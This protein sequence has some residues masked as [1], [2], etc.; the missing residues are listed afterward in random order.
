M[1]SEI[2]TNNCLDPK[3]LSSP[4]SMELLA[5][6]VMSVPCGHLVE[7]DE[8]AQLTV[9]KI[10]N[11]LC[12]RAHVN[13]WIPCPHT[14]KK[15]LQAEMQKAHQQKLISDDDIKSIP[16]ESDL[17][18]VDKL[19]REIFLNQAFF[20]P[21]MVAPC[22]CVTEKDA[23]VKEIFEESGQCPCCQKAATTLIDYPPVFK[24]LLQL[25]FNRMLA[26]KQISYDELSFDHHHF[27]MIVGAR[28]F[29]TPAGERFIEVL[30]NSQRHLN[31]KAIAILASTREGRD[32]LRKNLKIE[33][34]QFFFKNALISAE[35]LQIDVDG[36]NI[37]AWLSIPT[38]VEIIEEE[39]EKT[40]AL[41][42]AEFTKAF[43]LKEQ[44][45]QSAIL[46]EEQ[47]AF[48]QLLLSARKQG[49]FRN[50]VTAEYARESCNAVDEILQQVVYGQRAVVRATL[51]NLKNTNPALLK[52]VLTSVSTK[53][54]TDY[55][56]K[57]IEN[58]TLLQAAAAANDFT[59]HPELANNPAHQ[60]MCDIIQSYFDPTDRTEQA[61]VA[62]QY[63]YFLKRSLQQYIEE[64]QKEITRLTA[65]KAAGKT[66]DEKCIKDAT[67]RL[68][69]YKA[70][71]DTGYTRRIFDIHKQAQEE[72]TF[73][74]SKIIAAITRAGNAPDQ[75]RA[76]LKKVGASFSEADDATRAKPDDQLTL[77]ESLNRFREQF[78]RYALNKIAVNPYDLIKA[79]QTYDDQFN[80]WA[81]WGQRF[82]FA[83]QIIGFVQRYL[84]AADACVFA[85][86]LYD[87]VDNKCV[88]P[89]HFTFENDRSYHFYPNLR[90]CVGLGFDYLAGWGAGPVC[91]GA[92]RGAGWWLVLASLQNLCRAKTADFQNLCSSALC[93]VA[94][95]N[96]IVAV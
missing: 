93:A 63:K 68:T 70:A 30:E 14:F 55:S 28:K 44:E 69:R 26:Q 24:E 34:G 2:T 56:G 50:T 64:Q 15:I 7:A 31:G 85:R 60:G 9:R 52:K 29:N 11:C 4:I 87:T 22:G 47:Q 27:S 36:K 72:N 95:P 33:S 18:N 8:A 35:S 21:M 42:Q 1:R 10:E 19:A 82:L 76:A 53:P 58:L 23:A 12:C 75:V 25:R 16:F 88:V 54:I 51:E 66:V 83:R 61:E 77:T 91:F 20:E 43:Y 37:L 13:E 78:E 84:S 40:A 41:M 65:L 80:N 92:S 62:E 67:T 90:L 45:K 79:F 96:T 17:E 6:P 32:L 71:I 74:F 57:K 3:D 86:G 94:R 5:N 49:L 39:A 89:D 59:I 73:D 38:A 46:A 81:S 48:R